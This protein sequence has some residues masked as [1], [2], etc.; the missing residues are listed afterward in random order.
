[1]ITYKTLSLIKSVF[2]REL[3]NYKINPEG[4]CVLI[5]DPII[6]CFEKGS[7]TITREGRVVEELPLNR[8]SMKRILSASYWDALE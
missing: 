6:L 2:E 8:F 3:I 4:R 5:V 1:M 7:V